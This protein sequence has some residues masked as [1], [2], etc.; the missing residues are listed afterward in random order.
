MGKGK[1]EGAMNTMKKTLLVLMTALFVT[2][3][4]Y[5]A[6]LKGSGGDPVSI[7]NP[8]D[9]ATATIKDTS[10]NIVY[11]AGNYFSRIV[12]WTSVYDPSVLTSLDCDGNECQDGNDVTTW[13][14][15]KG[16]Y[17]L[18][19]PTET[20]VD[21][22]P[23]APSLV[24]GA[25]PNSNGEA[26][27]SCTAFETPWACC[28]GGTCTGATPSTCDGSCDSKTECED[29]YGGFWTGTGTCADQTPA[30]YFDADKGNDYANAEAL[31]N[32]SLNC[33]DSNDRC[34]WFVVWRW[35]NY[36]TVSQESFLSTHETEG[37]TNLSNRG[38]IYSVTWAPTPHKVYNGG[39]M[40]E[41]LSEGF[42]DPNEQIDTNYH[43]LLWDING[44]TDNGYN[45]LS[46]DDWSYH[47]FVGPNTRKHG[48]DIA[49][50]RDHN[51]HHFGYFDFCAMGLYKGDLTQD[52]GFGA[53]QQYVCNTW[54]LGLKTD[55]DGST[56]ITIDRAT[57]S[58]ILLS[59][60]WD[61]NPALYNP[62]KFIGDDY[63]RISAAMTTTGVGAWT[64]TGTL[65]LETN[66]SGSW[67]TIPTTC[68][69]STTLCSPEDPV[70]FSNLQDTNWHGAQIFASTNGA[71]GTKQVWVR[72]RLDVSDDPSGPYYSDQVKVQVLPLC[73]GLFDCKVYALSDDLNTGQISDGMLCED[74]NG[75]YWHPYCTVQDA[76]DGIKN[77]WGITSIAN[78]NDTDC[79]GLDNP[80]DCCFGVGLGNCDETADLYIIVS[81]KINEGQLNITG[82]DTNTDHELIIEGHTDFDGK[83][84]LEVPG[85]VQTNQGP[86]MTLNGF[87]VENT[88]D[89]DVYT[90]SHTATANNQA[91]ITSD[92]NNLILRNIQCEINND[93]Y[94]GASC[95]KLTGQSSG[96]VNIL[97]NIRIK[98]SSGTTGSVTGIDIDDADLTVSIY[99]PLIYGLD[100]SGVTS[101]GIVSNAGTVNVY[102]ATV[103]CGG[104]DG[105]STGIDEVGG[106]MSVDNTV[107][108]QCD[109]RWAGTMAGNKNASD[110]TD[111]ECPADVD[112]CI[113][114]VTLTVA[115]DFTDVAGGDYSP[116]NADSVLWASGDNDP[117]SGGYSN[118][119][120]GANR[121]QT[122]GIGAFEKTI[123][124]DSPA[125]G[126]TVTTTTPTFEFTGTESTNTDASTPKYGVAYNIQIF[127][128]GEGTPII[129]A[130]T[131]VLDST[132]FSNTVTPTDTYTFNQ[133][134]KMD[135]DVQAGDA[136]TDGNTYDWR[137]RV[138]APYDDDTWSAWSSL[139]TFTVTVP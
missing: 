120:T 49:G 19:V 112:S 72:A 57:T 16:L 63:M 3:N 129:D 113:T 127:N 83:R 117:S 38:K 46:I 27:T 52:P 137:V 75:T 28:T 78:M 12:N 130:E 82:I 121:L 48:I 102:N 68:T 58:D 108:V 105:T 9:G 132:G 42:Y 34:S 23:H 10:G 24:M 93:V 1:G 54:G 7:K 118:S 76:V 4:A 98:G 59:T 96:A 122:W 84:V 45:T 86:L 70:V 139:W 80:W 88:W 30:I 92:I 55:C 47:G 91:T 85:L 79:A 50:P 69:T 135:Y 124:L 56:S 77:H 33:A 17:D 53:L 97:E 131:T 99:N 123:G 60:E 125:N 6:T 5:S 2:V 87:N 73:H 110:A 114:T 115:D 101:K 31:H 111:S 89:N 62:V 22:T 136:L 81:G 128:T 11:P 133:G 107:V 74:G 26:N 61:I 39:T 134:E 40:V 14:D 44:F 13:G 36:P 65:T 119:A 95:I 8:A 94:T 64:E 116:Y 35:A 21:Q 32:I 66:Q 138:K 25:C 67:A 29:T 71:K 15:I 100:A 109:D 37:E 18:T 106:T 104:T 43:V 90:F 41:A 51:A 126:S 20:S 103:D